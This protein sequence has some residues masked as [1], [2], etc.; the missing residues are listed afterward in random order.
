MRGDSWNAEARALLEGN[1]IGKTDGLP[2]RHCRVLRRRA[3]GTVR[4]RAEAPHPFADAR[5]VDARAHRVDLARAVALRNHARI[6]HGR[7][8]PSLPLLDLARVHARCPQPDAHV[9]GSR[10]RIRHLADDEDVRGFALLFVP[11]C[12]HVS[13]PAA[14]D[15]RST[16]FN[17]TIGRAGLRRATS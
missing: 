6:R 7:A 10:L 3:E 12:L 11:G 4:L 15:R 2:R 16:N 1:A 5:R 13:A 17:R 9:T 8:Q 14:G